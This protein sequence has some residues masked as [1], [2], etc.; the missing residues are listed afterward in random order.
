VDFRKLKQDGEVV[1]AAN[2]QSRRTQ[3]AMMENLMEELQEDESDGEKRSPD[4]FEVRADV[5]LLLES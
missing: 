2:E 5:L 3:A 4:D 1:V